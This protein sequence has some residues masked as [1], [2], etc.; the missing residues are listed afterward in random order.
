[1]VQ[2]SVT[3]SPNTSVELSDVATCNG[4]EGELTPK[5][6]AGP[7]SIGEPLAPRGTSSE[8]VG[9]VG[10]PYGVIVHVICVVRAMSAG[11]STDKRKLEFRVGV[12]GVVGVG[13][14]T[15]IQLAISISTE[16]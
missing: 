4:P 2:T 14:D 13:P 6:R 10:V 8:I 12:Q 11:T 15:G 1:M 16:T 9:R 5:H 3:K 7:G